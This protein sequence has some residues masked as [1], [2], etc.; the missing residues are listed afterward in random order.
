MLIRKENWLECYNSTKNRPGREILERS[1]HL[2][3]YYCRFVLQLCAVLSQ[4][5]EHEEALCFSKKAS[6]LAS[7]LT[8]MTLILVKE[9]TKPQK[10][11]QDTSII[12]DTTSQKSKRRKHSKSNQLDPYTSLSKQK[13][14]VSARFNN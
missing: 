10:A 2:T 14:T 12:G 6:S 11:A 13:T 8:E 4:L 3:R 5:N 7:D 1:I 9:E